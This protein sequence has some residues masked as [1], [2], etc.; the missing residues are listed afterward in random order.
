[1]HF[2][3]KPGMCNGVE[4][5]KHQQA[6]SHHKQ[7]I[8]SMDVT[9]RNYMVSGSIDNVICFWQAYSCKE[10]KYVEIP[11]P[12]PTESVDEFGNNK[13]QVQSNFIQSVRF[14]DKDSS[15]FVIVV[16]SE[17]EVFVLENATDNFQGTIRKRGPVPYP[18][19]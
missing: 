2:V 16:M 8:V 12:A 1:M 5:I 7:D 6:P 15:E 9:S 17:G 19:A 3:T 4:S 14:A 13:I 18:T 10:V 11:R